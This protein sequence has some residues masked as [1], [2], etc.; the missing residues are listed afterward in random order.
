MGGVL[1]GFNGLIKLDA[2]SW[3]I[4]V[5]VNGDDCVYGNVSW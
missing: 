5:S 1:E 3:I 2:R 4:C